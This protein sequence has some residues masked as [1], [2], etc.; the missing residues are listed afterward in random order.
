MVNSFFFIICRRA[1]LRKWKQRRGLKSTYRNLIFAF[2]EAGKS[3]C[4]EAVCRVLG[5]MVCVHTYMYVHLLNT[6]LI[7]DLFSGREFSLK[8]ASVYCKSILLDFIFSNASNTVKVA[9]S[10]MQSLIRRKIFAG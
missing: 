7:A 3:D 1:A 6:I 2:L 9:T 10:I 8:L 4:A 5:G